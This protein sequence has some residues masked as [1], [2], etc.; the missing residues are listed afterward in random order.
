MTTTPY[1]DIM[2]DRNPARGTV[3]PLSLV[4][5]L[6]TRFAA[7]GIVDAGRRSTELLARSEKLA[8]QSRAQ[9]VAARTAVA[10]AMSDLAAGRIGLDQVAA[11]TR[12]VAPWID[13]NVQD[14]RAAPAQALTMRT[15]ALLQGDA[16]GALQAESLTL[17]TRL[18]T[19]A[20]EAVAVIVSGP[21]IPNAVMT[22]PDAR[23][24]AT[25]AG[26]A[27]AHW[28]VDA[29]AAAQK[30]SEAHALAEI[31][32]D[33]VGGLH[34]AVVWPGSCPSWA[35]PIWRNWK[36]AVEDDALNLPRKYR[37]LVV[38]VRY[39]HEQ[40]W[41]PGLWTAQDLIDRQEPEK[42]GLLNRLTGGLPA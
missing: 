12:E 9:Q 36:K 4:R 14:G 42:R 26:P 24:A 5:A 27:F 38:R 29:E 19:V 11:V 35:G 22:A 1:I 21:K 15:V 39:A 8:E 7:L 30:F 13:H 3:S 33:Q 20:G 34:A 18:Q 6:P 37:S 32:R 2:A 17:Y 31:L 28:W 16:V 41:E 23:A 25:S 10:Q 40:G